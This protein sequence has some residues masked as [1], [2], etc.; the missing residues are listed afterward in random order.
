[1]A[2]PSIE[3]LIYA[4]LAE[5][6]DAWARGDW[7]AVVT[8]LTPLDRGELMTTDQPNVALWRYRLAEA[9][10]AL[11][12]V[13]DAQRLLTEAVERS[14]GGVTRAE[15]IRLQAQLDHRRGRTD[16][17][18]AALA[19]YA[20]GIDEN[21]RVLAEGLLALDLGRILLASRQRRAAIVPLQSARAIFLR[22]GAAGLVDQCDSALVASGLPA[23]EAGSGGDPVAARLTDREQIVARLVAAGL[24]NREAAAE[25][26]V[27][28]K[29]IE[30][31]L[32][33]I[34][35]K[36]GMTSRRQ[37]RDALA[38]HALS[39]DVGEP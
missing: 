38:G 27:S 6:Y 10:L 28:V 15:R 32:R 13:A 39:G 35:T 8:A 25:L 30:Y 29:A 7:S 18:V 17:A 2:L 24:T 9:Y 19:A 20:E 11:G 5:S 23:G 36:L 1:V 26:Y 34:Y 33:N 31:H 12:Q 16:E 4:A 3:A 21:S 14:W 37:L 22:L